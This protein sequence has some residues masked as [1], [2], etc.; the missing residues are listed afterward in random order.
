MAPKLF[1]LVVLALACATLNGMVDV[2][3][4]QPVSATLA[5]DQLADDEVAAATMR[6]YSSL[7]NLLP[8]VSWGSGRT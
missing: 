1:I 2:V 6:S 7:M 8:I 4:Q 5:V 3:I